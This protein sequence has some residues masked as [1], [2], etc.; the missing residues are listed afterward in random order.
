MRFFK[1]GVGQA[2]RRLKT[3]TVHKIVLHA[4]YVDY[5]VEEAARVPRYVVRD[6]NDPLTEFHDFDFRERFRMSKHSFAG[7]MAVLNLPENPDRR[8][9]PISPAL[10]VLIPLRFF[11]CGTFH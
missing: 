11:A 5:L 1:P 6:R 3:W 9:G 8:G 4:D 7:L 2:L 10:S